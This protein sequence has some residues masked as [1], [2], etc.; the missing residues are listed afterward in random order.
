VKRAGGEAALKVMEDHLAKHEWFVGN[1][2]SIA[3]IALYAYTHVADGGGF[4]LSPYPAVNRW[5]YMVAG[6]QGH[7]L[8]SD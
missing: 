3:D 7:V 2:Y 6:Q 5:L 1:Q 8:L 4:S